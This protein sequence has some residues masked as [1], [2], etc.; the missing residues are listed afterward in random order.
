MEKSLREGTQQRTSTLLT[1]TN[2][3]AMHSAMD[4]VAQVL[5]K[6]FSR[7]GKMTDSLLST[8][9]TSSKPNKQRPQQTLIDKELIAN[10]DTISSNGMEKE[11]IKTLMEERVRNF[12]SSKPIHT[13]LSK[14]DGVVNTIE[15]STEC[16]QQKHVYTDEQNHTANGANS[17]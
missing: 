17:F 3:A 14:N 13:I 9:K 8:K 16:T 5:G 1:T 15:P 6:S 7:A 2:R 4:K 11:D 12:Y 10:S